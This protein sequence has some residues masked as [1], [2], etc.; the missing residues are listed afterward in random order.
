LDNGEKIV[1]YPCEDYWLD[2]GNHE[3][4]AKAQEE[5]ESRKDKFLPGDEGSH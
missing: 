1:G 3:D 2:V 4:Y 5:F